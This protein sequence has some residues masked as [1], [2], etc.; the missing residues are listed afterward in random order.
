ME[1]KIGTLLTLEPTYTDRIEK[2][3][4]RIVERQNN[5]I[6]ID[7]PINVM[8]NKTAFLVD[9]AQF[10]VTF[11]TDKRENFCFN[12]EVL[13]RRGGDIQMILLSCPPEDE[14]IKIQRREYVRVETPVDVAIEHN[15]RYYQLVAED[16]SAGGIAIHLKSP[17]G[18]TEGEIVKLVIVL[19]FANGD[20]RY[21][22]TEANVVRI[23]ERDDV[24]IASIQ[25]TN[26][27]DID[28]QHIVRFCFER[29]LMI[30][31][32]ELNEI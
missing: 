3:R 7:Y 27:D 18:F 28:Q 31:K 23:F 19:P 5:I 16:I 32:K 26:T 2:F 21:V 9:G 25:F 1:L 4:C 30:R 24:N 22:E 15:N 13:G 12:T 8:T 11:T 6:F 14:F 17:V 20:M 10:R 29:Q